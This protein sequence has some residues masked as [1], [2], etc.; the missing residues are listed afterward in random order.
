MPLYLKSPQETLSF[1]TVPKIRP[2]K[3]AQRLAFWVRRPPGGV[4]VFL[5][6][7]WGSKT[8]C[9]PSK[10]R[11]PWVLK[12]GIWDV[13]G[14][15]PGCPGPLGVFKKFVLKKFVRIFR[16]L[17]KP[18]MTCV[19][20]KQCTV[21]LHANLPHCAYFTHIQAPHPFT[22]SETISEFGRRSSG[23]RSIFPEIPLS[24]S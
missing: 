13:P 9:S 17:K 21:S 3:R 19:G 11:L 8:S 22:S 6:K 5:A 16:S 23:F 18:T 15:L 14:I 7:G 24:A 4:G 10:V 1:F 20:P 2:E 12:R